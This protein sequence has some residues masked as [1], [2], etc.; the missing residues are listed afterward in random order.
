MGSVPASHLQGLGFKS[1][2]RD[3]L[4]WL[5]FISV[6]LVYLCAYGLMVLSVAQSE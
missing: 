3:Y 2:T 6:L 1:Q 4:S 5:Q